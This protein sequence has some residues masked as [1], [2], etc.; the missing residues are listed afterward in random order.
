MG[1]FDLGGLGGSLSEH[2]QA[3]G[4]QV[5]RSETHNTLGSSAGANFSKLV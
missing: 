2:F 1:E 4:H 5:C 3:V